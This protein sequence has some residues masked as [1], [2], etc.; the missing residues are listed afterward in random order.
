MKV[1]LIS[2]CTKNALIETRRILDQF[3]E[4]K[5]GGCWATEITEQGLQTL[6]KLLRSSARKNT[7]VSCLKI[8]G[9][10]G[11]ELLWI[12]GDTT[13]F[14]SQGSVPT[15]SS[16]VDILKS[17]SE[18]DW[19]F[20]EGLKILVQIAALFHDFG[21]ASKLFQAKLKKQ[22][23]KNYE[24]YRHEWVSAFVFKHFVGNMTDKDWL[25]KLS[26]LSTKNEKDLLKDEKELLN[27]L[28]RESSSRKINPF[29]KV[30]NSPLARFILWLILSH[31]RLPLPPEEAG[32]MDDPSKWMD[33]K[34]FE[35][36]WNSP[37]YNKKADFE[38]FAT[39][40]EEN[41]NFEEKGT[42]FRSRKWIENAG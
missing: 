25:R 42:L 1:L 8:G 2:E 17:A 24:P 13:K 18:N 12:V 22:T 26:D 9:Y 16:K 41:F 32:N 30:T 33:S 29:F 23:K 19:D 35:A 34:R 36:S 5:G 21:K 10:Q 15:N 3:A 39:K 4:R 31:H 40:V 14:S 6:K 27:E 20:L 37:K 11:F 28:A 38:D 7:A